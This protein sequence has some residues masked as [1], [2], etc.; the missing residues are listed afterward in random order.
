MPLPVSDRGQPLSQTVPAQ[1]RI[2]S[3]LPV[4]LP[5]VSMRPNPA[6]TETAPS[7][8]APVSLSSFNLSCFRS[9][10]ASIAAVLP[11]GESNCQAGRSVKFCH[12]WETSQ[13]PVQL[14][15][16]S[17]LFCD[18]HSMPKIIFSL[19]LRAPATTAAA[20]APDDEQ[21]RQKKPAH[22]HAHAH[23]L[24]SASRPV[25]PRP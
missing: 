11:Y 7:A 13:N 8:S 16:G 20:V 4:W 17:G 1:T 19:I 9:P 18:I 6:R 14:L 21:H 2:C 15:L 24:P 12:S 23:A 3:C 25:Q 22:N 10:F 5:A